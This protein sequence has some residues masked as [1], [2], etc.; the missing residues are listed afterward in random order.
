[1]SRPSHSF[2]VDDPNDT[3]T[4]LYLPNFATSCLLVH[5][6]NNVVHSYK[7]PTNDNCQIKCVVTAAEQKVQET[8]Q[9]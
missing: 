8:K 9:N 7:R 2:C 5:R 4:L 6:A 1:M 3:G